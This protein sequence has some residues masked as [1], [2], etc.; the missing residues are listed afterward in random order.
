MCLQELPQ[1]V[2][3]G[4][5][6][7]QPEQQE[8]EEEFD[9]SDIMGEQVGS[10]L[11]TEERL[12]QIEQEEQVPLGS[13]RLKDCQLELADCLVYRRQ[14]VEELSCTPQQASSETETQPV[15]PCRSSRHN[16]NTR[17]SPAARKRK[18]TGPR[19]TRT[20]NSD[21][22]FAQVIIQFGA[23]KGSCPLCRTGCPQAIAVCGDFTVQGNNL[24]CPVHES[25]ARGIAKWNLSVCAIKQ[26]DNLITIPVLQRGGR[27]QAPAAGQSEPSGPGH[28][29]LAFSLTSICS[30]L[31]GTALTSSCCAWSPKACTGICQEKE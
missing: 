28:T 17:L 8:I 11:S 30:R 26:F 2:D 7:M 19:N 5:A 14:A 31:K 1:L 9:L 20:M 18:E 22:L 15:T 23:L 3:G 6:V 25:P 29:G 10:S 27:L 12:K 16:R 21:Q 24:H 4:E 13:P